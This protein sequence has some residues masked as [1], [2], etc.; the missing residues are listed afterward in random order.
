MTEVCWE[1]IRDYLARRNESCTTII[2]PAHLLVQAIGRG[3]KAHPELNRRV[4]GRRIHEFRGCNVCLAIRCTRDREVYVVVIEGAE[5]C[6]LAEIAGRVWEYQF[7]IH[8]GT[9]AELRDRQRL[10]R[11]PGGLY[12]ALLRTYEWFDRHWSLP[13]MGRLDR[14]RMSPVLCNDFSFSGAPIMRG[15]KPSRFPDSS[16]PISVTLGAVEEKVVW[17][18]GRAYPR[19]IA[20]LSVRID[21]RIG[22]GFQ[23]AQFVATLC[24]LLSRPA[25]M[26]RSSADVHASTKNQPTEQEARQSWK[27]I[28]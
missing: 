15:Y 7:S 21:H 9:C 5:Q 19:L 24:Q 8:R 27:R 2:T 28:A 17:Q 11:L 13:V 25:D 26:E 18:D 12:R 23:L 22:D 3:L 14:L 20:P 10:R 1:P 4:V 16:K 6:S